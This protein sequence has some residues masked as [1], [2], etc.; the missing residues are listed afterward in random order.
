MAITGVLPGLSKSPRQP[1]GKGAQPGGVVVTIRRPPPEVKRAA[2]PPITPRASSSTSSPRLPRIEAAG[3]DVAAA[4]SPRH[5]QTP[6]S[7]PDPP[8]PRARSTPPHHYQTPRSQPNPPLPRALSMT[9]PCPLRPPRPA[10]HHAE[11]PVRLQLAVS[12]GGAVAATVGARTPLPVKLGQSLPPMIGL[13]PCANA[14]LSSLASLS[15]FGVLLMYPDLSHWPPHK[16]RR[17]ARCTCGA[18]PPLSAS[19]EA[20]AR[21]AEA[22]AVHRWPCKLS[23]R[24][25]THGAFAPSVMVGSREELETARFV[26]KQAKWEAAKRARLA[27]LQAKLLAEG[28]A[29]P[30]AARGL[31]ASGTRPPVGAPPASRTPRA[32]SDAGR[33]DRAGQRRVTHAAKRAALLL[34]AQARDGLA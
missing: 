27:K 31:R 25:G 22:A 17:V 23:E 34:Q 6:R 15:S 7:Q 13:T 24:A 8:P 30:R 18:L 19:G 26:E 1:V 32:V 28:A 33:L 21:G 10:V 20:D 3:K 9:T 12:A 5:H 14:S 2:A 29:S 4:P 16:H 11:P